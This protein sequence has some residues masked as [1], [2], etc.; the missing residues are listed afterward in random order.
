MAKSNW[1]FTSVYEDELYIYYSKIDKQYLDFFN[2][3]T[4]RKRTINAWTINKKFLIHQGKHLV[5]CQTT[6]FHQTFK[7]GSFTKTRKPFFFRSKKKKR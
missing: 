7:F 5:A 4:L 2:K 1:K 6:P 3:L